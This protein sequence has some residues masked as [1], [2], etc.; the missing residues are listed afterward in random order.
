VSGLAA[1]YGAEYMRAGD[2]DR[3]PGAAW[4][5]FNLLVASMA[6]VIV[7][8]NAVLFL[9]AWELMTLASFFL[10]TWDD[11]EAEVREAGW[12]YLV[13]AHLGTVWLLA[14]FVLLGRE[15]GSLDFDR[16]GP[17]SG[18][19]MLFLLA[20]VGFGTKAGWM[21]VHVWLPEAHPAAPSHVSASCRA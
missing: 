15:G 19:G 11:R 21:P 13:A 7:A 16:F 2:D 20:V 5:L 4:F 18:A 17:A 3:S 9:V 6:V 8:R 14:L 1:V 10:V 12:T